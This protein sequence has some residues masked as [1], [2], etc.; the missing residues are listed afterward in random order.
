MLAGFGG[1][2]G[3]DR[4]LAIMLGRGLGSGMGQGSICGAVS[5][6]FVILG[7][8]G[9]KVSGDERNT[10]SKT[11]ALCRK[12]SERFMERH[13]ALLC[14][15]LLSVNPTTEAGKKEASEK[16]LIVTRCPRFVEDAAR[17]LND[18]LSEKEL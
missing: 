15:E 3:L 5:G 8:A 10:R 16:K 14:S 9:G 13:K 7:L 4:D 1:S 2:L 6:A 11:Y 12:F 18:L 17:I